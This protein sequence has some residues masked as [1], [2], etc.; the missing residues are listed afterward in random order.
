MHLKENHEDAGVK[1]IPQNQVRMDR[2]YKCKHCKFHVSGTKEQFWLH[3]E[4]HMN[5][6]KVKRCPKCPFVTEFKHHLLYH[7][8]NHLGQK[9]FKCPFC[10]YTCVNKAM[11]SSHL[12]YSHGKKLLDGVIK[13]KAEPGSEI[14]TKLRLFRKKRTK[15]PKSRIRTT[16]EFNGGGLPDKT[17]KRS[18]VLESRVSGNLDS[19]SVQIILENSKGVNYCVTAV[20]NGLTEAVPIEKDTLILNPENAKAKVTEE[21]TIEEMLEKTDEKSE[22]QI[23]VDK[24]CQNQPEKPVTHSETEADVELFEVT[25]DSVTQISVDKF[26]GSQPEKTMKNSETAGPDIPKTCEMNYPKPV[27]HPLSQ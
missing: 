9:P 11:L 2:L 26:Y 19:D 21:T 24:F 5:P 18:I 25:D 7:T 20:D 3:A 22:V 14:T 27:L 10:V 15:K 6:E 13:E 12:K 17:S 4:K 16:S 1:K 23:T 8:R